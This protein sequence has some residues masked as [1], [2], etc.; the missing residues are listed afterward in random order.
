LVRDNSQIE[1]PATPEEGYHLTPDLVEKAKAM[2]ADAKQVAPNKPFFMYLCTGAMHA[3][4]PRAEGMGL[5]VQ[6][7][8]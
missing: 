5:Q 4:A 8:V 3:P 2:I 1:P 7:P 6:R